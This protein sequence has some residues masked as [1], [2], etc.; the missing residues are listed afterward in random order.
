MVALKM[1]GIK[2]KN[3]TKKVGRGRPAGAVSFCVVPVKK[4]RKFAPSALITVSRKW[5]ES[6]GIEGELVKN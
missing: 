1:K 3:G 4:L 6:V 5:A 2:M